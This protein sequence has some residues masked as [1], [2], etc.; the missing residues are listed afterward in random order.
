M[1]VALRIGAAAFAITVAGLVL[2][3]A[4]G[5]RA[6]AADGGATQSVFARGRYLVVIGAC[7]DCHTPGWRESDGSLPPSRWL[8]GSRIGFRG[9]WGTSYPVN[10]RLEF[11]ALGE[12]QWVLAVRTRGGHPPMIWHDLRALTVADRHAIFAFIHS[13]GPAGVPAPTAIPPWREPST[14]Y[15]E[16]RPRNPSPP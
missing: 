10:L 13:L 12:D 3:G 1:S 14:P 15:V 16:T 4:G 7:N 5:A 6:A 11:Q 2:N 8:T 9:D